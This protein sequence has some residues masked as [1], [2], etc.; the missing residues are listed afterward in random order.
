MWPSLGKC[1]TVL[2]VFA[3]IK[4]SSLNYAWIDHINCLSTKT[5]NILSHCICPC[6]VTRQ[7]FW[8]TSLTKHGRL[9][10]HSLTSFIHFTP[11]LVVKGLPMWDF[12]CETCFC[13]IFWQFGT[14]FPC[15]ANLTFRFIVTQ[16]IQSFAS[17][18]CLAY[19][20]IHPHLVK[21]QCTEKNF[22]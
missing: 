6:F 22:L 2:W 4:L 5:N 17:A 10:T 12:S 9:F 8:S 18:I 13:Q 11:S 19:K 3:A 21:F 7:M 16:L 14:E 20:W 15:L 1:T